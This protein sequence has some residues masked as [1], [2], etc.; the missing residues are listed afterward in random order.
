MPTQ[1][2]L[3]EHT[4]NADA[5]KYVETAESEELVAGEFKHATRL[6][7]FRPISEAVDGFDFDPCA[8]PKSRLAKHNVRGEGGLAVDWSEYTKIWL[9]HPFADPAPWLKKAVECDAEL[10]VALSKFDASTE[11]FQKYATEADLICIPYE[12]MKFGEHD[13]KLRDQLFFSVYGDY[14]PELREHF[15]SIGLCTS[16]RGDLM[17]SWNDTL[18]LSEVSRADSIRVKFSSPITIN[19]EEYET[20]TLT[21]LSFSDDRLEDGVV[22]LTCVLTHDDGTETWFTL[23]QSGNADQTICRRHD[24]TDGWQ[25]EFVQFISAPT[26]ID[27]TGPSSQMFVA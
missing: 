27:T 25:H 8:S 18:L 17:E 23:S 22:E 26:A 11:W 2:R 3:L 6:E 20:V 9:N 10:V 5:G 4:E 12:R 21:P 15:E 24:K 16:G 19:H 13:D 14:P 1:S 7:D